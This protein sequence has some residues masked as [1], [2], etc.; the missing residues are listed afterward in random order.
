MTVTKS[1][2]HKLKH[3]NPMSPFYT[4]GSIRKPT[5]FLFSRGIEKEHCLKL[6]NN[7]CDA[8]VINKTKLKLL[9]QFDFFFSLIFHVHNNF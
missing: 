6:V 8:T 7:H 2:T 5:G 9:Y 4:P 3:F 1:F